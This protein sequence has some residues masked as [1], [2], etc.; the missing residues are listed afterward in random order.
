ME[1]T[2][3]ALLGRGPRRGDLVDARRSSA[4]CCCGRRCAG[5]ATRSTREEQ[6]GAFLLGLRRLGVVPHGSLRRARASRSAIERRRARR[7]RG[8]GRA[9][10]RARSAGR[11]AAARARRRPSAAASVP[12]AAMTARRGPRPA[13]ASTWPTS[14]SSIPRASPRSTRFKEDLEA[15]SLDLY[16][17]VQELEDTYGVKMSDEEAARILTV[18]QAVDFVARP[19]TRAEALTPAQLHD[20][21]DALPDDLARQAFTHASWVERRVGLLRAAGLPGRLRARPGGHHAPVPAAGGRALRRRAADEDPR[22]GG[23][24]AARAARW[25]SGWAAGAAARRRRRRTVAGRGAGARWCDRARAGLGDR[26][27]DRRLLPGVRLRARRRRRWWR[28]SR[29]RSRRRSSTRRTSSR[30]CRSGWRGAGRVVAYEV[31]GRG[32]PAARA[33][34]RGRGRWS[35]GEE[36]GRGCGRSK[37][38]AEQ[39]AAEAALD[40]LEAA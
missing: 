20:L 30:R 11:R 26:G 16:T 13:S 5:C 31:V 34:L 39:A 28:R 18:G 38:D 33:H 35:T 9:H 2:S 15:D 25:P 4:G 29:R 6:G 17:L 3:A 1:G 32:G 36:V 24:A 21:L 19:T 23:L 8:R 22:A 14:W 27:G 40:A 7:A 37:K 10:A 12:R